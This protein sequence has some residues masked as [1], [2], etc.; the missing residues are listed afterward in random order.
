MTTQTPAPPT[1]AYVSELPRSGAGFGRLLYAEWTKFR[2]V[3]RWTFVLLVSIALTVLVSVLAAGGSQISGGGPAGP[4]LGPD[5]KPV[6]DSFR[7]VHQPLAGDGTVTTRVDKLAADGFELPNGKKGRS[8]PWAKAGL[9][10][11]AST[12]PGSPYAAIML[13]GREGVRFQHGFRH[14]VAG[15][16]AVPDRPTWLRLTRTGS[17][18]TGYTS[19]DGAKWTEVGSAK[20]PGLAETAQVGMF[21][22]SPGTFRLERQFGSTGVDGSNTFSTGTFSAYSVDGRTSGPLQGADVAPPDRPVAGDGADARDEGPGDGPADPAPGRS[23]E[24]SETN[25]VHT[26]TA[27]GDIGPMVPDFD[28]PQQGLSGAA[29]GLIPLAAL[30]VLFITAE[31]K[32]GMIATTFTATPRRGRVLAA[33]AV[34]VG[35]V[36]FVAGLVASVVGFLVSQP[37]MRDNGYKPPVFPEWALT[38][39]PV[40]RAVVGTA[41]VMAL[42]AVFALALGTLLRN[43]AAAVTLVIVLFVLPQI[44]SS[45]MPVDAA[46]LMLRVVPTAGFSVQRTIEDYPQVE[47]PCL[48]EEG[49]YAQGPGGGLAVLCV[50]VAVALALAAWQLRRRRA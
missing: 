13:T 42:A 30:G 16:H 39:G 34:V 44:L 48:P 1:P 4:T 24:S 12:T 3:P 25:G 28:T 47:T 26:I 10:V 36:G 15:P 8:S 46:R 14:D 23:N 32:K 40:L 27:T 49:C 31:F 37:I 35:A 18:V 22:A 21:V 45:G 41:A 9:I 17:V 38:D 7:F 11:K 19:T 29:I 2:S 33:K 20:V 6:V 50:Y 5:G 43:T